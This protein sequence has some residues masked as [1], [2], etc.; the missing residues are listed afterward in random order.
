MEKWQSLWEE[1]DSRIEVNKFYSLPSLAQY[2]L[3]INDCFDGCY[4]LCG[5]LGAFFQNFVSGGR[6]MTRDNVKQ[7]VERTVKT[8]MLSASTQVLCICLMGS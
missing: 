1:I 6:V 4:D 5:S 7:F 2:Y 3:K 8:L